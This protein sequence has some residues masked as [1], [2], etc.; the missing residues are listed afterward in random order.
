MRLSGAPLGLPS[1]NVGVFW[2]GVCE[3]PS[4]S[5]KGEGWPG[6]R[7]PVFFLCVL[8]GLRVMLSGFRAEGAEGAERRRS[9]AEATEVR[10][11]K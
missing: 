11:P 6:G 9:P 2:S 3:F 7:L 5:V 4:F 10:A 8:C 1:V